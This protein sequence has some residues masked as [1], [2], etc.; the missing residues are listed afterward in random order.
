MSRLSEE[1]Y[2]I[3]TPVIFILALWHFP[4]F[5]KG[6]APGRLPIYFLK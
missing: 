2:K 5:E 6:F 3:T 1:E 4:F